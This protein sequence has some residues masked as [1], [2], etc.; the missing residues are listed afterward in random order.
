[1]DL[2]YKQILQKAA[3]A[4]LLD[5]SKELLSILDE[6]RLEGDHQKDRLR[7]FLAPHIAEPTL[8][9]ILALV[10]VVDE[11]RKTI[12]RKRILDKY[13]TLKRELEQ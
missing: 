7:S 9:A 3:S 6:V 1:M 8:S 4:K 11:N 5:L 13:N 2:T 10:V 12:L